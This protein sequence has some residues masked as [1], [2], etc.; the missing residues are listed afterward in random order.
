MNKPQE[1]TIQLEII[2]LSKESEGNP[3]AISKELG[4]P[5]EALAT[6]TVFRESM[7]YFQVITPIHR[8]LDL[9][10]IILMRESR[11]VMAMDDF[12][13]HDLTGTNEKQLTETKNNPFAL[14]NDPRMET[15]VDA[16]IANQEEI[17]ILIGNN[18]AIKTR[19]ATLIVGTRAKV[20]AGVSLRKRNE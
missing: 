13:W 10:A 4:V 2:E 17:A 9:R 3:E 14:A 11:W 1:L 20:L 18:Q 6:T 15:I 16:Q 7:G 12:A 8:N 5:E 19:I